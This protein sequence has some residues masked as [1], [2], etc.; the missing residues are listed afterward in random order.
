[1]RNIKTRQEKG[2]IL[3]TVLMM[4]LVLTVVGIAALRTSSLENTLSGN[5]LRNT[6]C[7][8]I[9]DSGLKP[10][11]G[12][13]DTLVA[14]S[15]PG[16]YAPYIPAGASTARLGQELRSNLLPPNTAD[17]SIDSG[18]ATADIA[19][20]AGAVNVLIDIDKTGAD[21]EGQG[22]ENHNCYEGVGKCS[23][24]KRFYYKINSTCLDPATGSR[25]IAGALY[26][27]VPK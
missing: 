17:T 6:E 1:M 7:K 5:I 27:Y 13:I 18:D 16:D 9:A 2:Y 14:D 4:L 23:G 24:S 22:I 3:V 21:S 19:F 8:E 26:M 15:D 11:S 10:A 12:A 25:S 20:T